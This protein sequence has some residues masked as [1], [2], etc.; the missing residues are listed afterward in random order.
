MSLTNGEI[1]TLN[2]DCKAIGIPSGNDVTLYE[3]TE[4][5]ITQALGGM[6]TVVTQQGVM[7]SIQGKDADALGLE[8]PPEAA[9]QPNESDK[10]TVEKLVWEKLKS[11]YDPE[12][13]HNVVDLGLIYE[14]DI[15]ETEKETYSVK[16]KM[17]LTAPGCGMG[18][19]MKRDAETKIRS[20]SGIHDCH[21]DIVFDPPWSPEKMNPVLRRELY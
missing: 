18:E 6:F 15:A 13:P 9:V 10:E 8:I 4:V 11:C 12:I 3:G 20:I 14:C 17:T 19:W 5:R 16:I 1:K 7:A 21:I 2:R